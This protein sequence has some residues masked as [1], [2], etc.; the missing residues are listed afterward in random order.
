MTGNCDPL[1][2][3]RPLSP[4]L[5]IASND[6][7]G[8]SDLFTNADD[9]LDIFHVILDRL[10]HSLRPIIMVIED[11]HWADQA[12]LDFL[13]FVGRRVSDTRT[14]VIVTY[15]DDEVGPDHPL[16]AVLGQ[17]IPLSRPQRDCRSRRSLPTPSR[18]WQEHLMSTRSSCTASPEE[19]R[20]S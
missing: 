13:R 15:R 16:R 3:P 20:S 1:S 7:A 11:V 6:D 4:L 19:M 10:R 5:D 8:F 17:L 14:V 12:T 18:G 9:N 2:T